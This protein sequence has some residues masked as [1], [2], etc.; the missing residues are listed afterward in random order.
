MQEKCNVH[1]LKVKVSERPRDLQENA[2]QTGLDKK[3]L[4]CEGARNLASKVIF[5]WSE[6][7]GKTLCLG[8]FRCI[9][10]GFPDAP[11]NPILI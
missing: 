5:W 9:P 11:P 1:A 4:H 10:L 7:F 2:E 3:W 8:F 6:N